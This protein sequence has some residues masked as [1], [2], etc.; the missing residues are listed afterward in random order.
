VIELS[1]QSPCTGQDQGLVRWQAGGSAELVA[2]HVGTD[3]QS[4]NEGIWALL[5]VLLRLKLCVQRK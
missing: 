4:L 2:V 3:L 5:R 1:C